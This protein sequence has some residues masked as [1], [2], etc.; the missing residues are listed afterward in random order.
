MNKKDK[1]QLNKHKEK[2]FEGAD[3]RETCRDTEAS[4]EFD[5]R[6]E[7]NFDRRMNDED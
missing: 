4:E 5:Y 6:A 3:R 1:N 2:K 7:F